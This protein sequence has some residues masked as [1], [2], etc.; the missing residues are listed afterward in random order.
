MKM[1]LQAFVSVIVYLLFFQIAAAQEPRA[2]LYSSEL[3][4]DLQKV[5]ANIQNPQQPVI[6]YEDLNTNPS[7]FVR[8]APRRHILTAENQI[9]DS[10]IL[11]TKPIIFL[12]TPEGIYGKAL[13]D[14]YLDIGY[15][16]EDIIRWQRDED[17]VAIVF[18][19]DESISLSAVKDGQLPEN[20]DNQVFV[21][22][23]D[24]M[25]SLFEQLAT[26]A[27]INP[28]QQGEFMP[29]ALSFRSE[30]LKNF[31][32][33]FPDVG[34]Q[35]VKT[36]PYT[37]LETVGGSDWLYRHLAEAK[38]SLFEHFRGTGRT[39][40][41]VVD[42]DGKQQYSGILEFVAPNKTVN[43]LPEIAIIHLGTL[44]IEEAY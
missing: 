6:P 42:P 30:E 23:W 1:R 5:V 4:D 8:I 24:N 44:K 25:F 17:M 28:E 41:E 27:T 13:L 21:P 3:S 39:L 15:E 19:Y 40:N 31:V 36:Q 37:S 26:N 18:R 20:W 10:A 35:R 9:Q 33:N 16:A 14:I 32:L 34:K 7:Y 11:G 22:T 12:A 38:L 43:T 2:L 29:T